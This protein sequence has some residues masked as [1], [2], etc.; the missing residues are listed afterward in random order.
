MNEIAE[1]KKMILDL[2]SKVNVLD[3]VLNCIKDI[4]LTSLAKNLSISRQT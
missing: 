1:L 2:T 3:A 4:P